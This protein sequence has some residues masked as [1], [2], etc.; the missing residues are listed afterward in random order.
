[1]SNFPAGSYDAV[2]TGE[3]QYGTTSNGND[4]IGLS[5]EVHGPEGFEAFFCTALLYFSPNAKQMSIAKL[6]ACGWSGSGDI[7]PQ[8]QGKPCRVGISYEEYK[9][10]QKMKVNIYDRPPGI[11]FDKPMDEQQK[12]KF[13]ASLAASAGGPTKPTNNGYPPGWDDPIGPPADAPPK[14]RLSLGGK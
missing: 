4:Q 10:E 1:M 5:L 7:G 11:K 14:G 9:G 2:C 8:I 3:V 13:L 12:S 6:K